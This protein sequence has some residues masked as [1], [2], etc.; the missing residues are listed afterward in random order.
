[1]KKN[2]STAAAGGQR[3]KRSRKEGRLDTL[4]S[5]EEGQGVVSDDHEERMVETFC[6]CEKSEDS[7]PMIDCDVWLIP[8]FGVIFPG[9]G[10]PTFMLT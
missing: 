8:P 4:P 5:R 1:M 10:V 3:G 6:Y 7:R 9:N 2:T